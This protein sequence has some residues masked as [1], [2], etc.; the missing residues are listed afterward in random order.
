MWEEQLNCTPSAQEPTK[1]RH[2]CYQK[3]IQMCATALVICTDYTS[4]ILSLLNN[5]KQQL[6]R[7]RLS[8]NVNMCAWVIPKLHIFQTLT[9]FDSRS[10][11]VVLVYIKSSGK[12][13]S[14]AKLSGQILINEPWWK[15]AYVI[16]IMLHFLFSYTHTFLLVYRS[17]IYKLTRQISIH[18]FSSLWKCKQILAEKH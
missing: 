12:E 14:V 1:A 4:S 18:H 16:Y 8:R 5:N 13:K 3:G 10:T 6:T 17:Y 9:Y 7:Y 2:M 11:G 15:L